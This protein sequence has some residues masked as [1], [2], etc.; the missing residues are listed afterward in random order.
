MNW[1]ENLLDIDAKLRLANDAKDLQDNQRLLALDRA[2]VEAHHRRTF[3]DAFQPA[4]APAE[5]DDGMIHIGDTIQHV[6]PAGGASTPP[7]PVPP[8]PDQTPT[9]TTPPTGGRLVRAVV[10]AASV[11]G[12][13][14]TGAV[15]AIALPHI[16]EYFRP[17]AAEPAPAPAPADPR[18]DN[19]TL[20]D[21]RLGGPHGPPLGRGA[22]P[23]WLS[24]MERVYQVPTD[25]RAN[26]KHRRK[27]LEAGYRSPRLA[28]EL[29]IMS[30]R[31][32]LFFSNT[33]LWTYANK[34]HD[35]RPVRPFILWDFQE[36]L[37]LEV[38]DAIGDHDLPVAKSRDMGASWICLSAFF[39]R[40]MFHEWQSLLVASRVQELVDKTGDPKTLF[41]KLDFLLDHLPIWMRPPG[42]I[43]NKNHL[44]NPSRNNTIEGT[45]TVA[46]MGVGDRKQ[47][48]LLDEAGLMEQ[49]S[50]IFA[51][52]RDTTN[53][54]IFNS[55]PRGV[56]GIGAA[57]HT[58]CKK[59]ERT[60]YL[61]WTA[62][63]IK[64]RGLYRLDG[65][66]QEPLIDRRDPETG[67][68]FPAYTFTPNDPDVLHRRIRS[69]WYDE[70]LE[71]ANS[72]VEIAQELD[73]S[74]VGSGAPYFRPEI[75]Q[76][77]LD[78]CTAPSAI[79]TIE[80]AGGHW[81]GSIADGEPCF[82][83]ELVPNAAEQGADGLL[84]IWLDLDDDGRPP[85]DREYVIGCDI[86]QGTGASNSVAS[87][88][89]RL[90]G[91]KVAELATSHVA[92]A[93]FAWLVTALADFFRGPGGPAL[94]I[95]EAAGPGGT[96]GR[97]LMEKC[98]HS[99]VYWYEDDTRSVSRVSNRAGWW[100]NRASKTRLLSDYRAQLQRNIFLNPSRA[101]LVEAGQ[102]VHDSGGF[103]MHAVDDAADSSDAGENH[104]D[105][106]IADAL[107]AKLLKDVPRDPPASRTTS[108]P[109]LSL[110]WRRE[111]RAQQ[112]R[113]REG[114]F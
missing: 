55:T 57:F 59:N 105:R 18:P 43:R 36:R 60:I 31:D 109:I 15:G 110:A 25:L 2:A 46:D 29:W 103:P 54:R 51:V 80:Y 38:L 14:A 69:P 100:P 12:A 61:H 74:F 89:D 27:C 58:Q 19:D 32:P 88:G 21:L 72:E 71:R 10:A 39:H 35:D 67:E 17:A 7:A 111:H 28:E 95:W 107:C 40:W 47:A 108:V 87:I 50:K 26:L 13:L 62:H 66:R 104:G 22:H 23:H 106:V 9:G 52:T 11:A 93:D 45:A 33:F 34:D 79:G 92:E 64:R 37:L 68:V 70:Q 86:S 84:R 41:W 112:R 99:N 44:E 56:T 6:Y 30:S 49:A 24:L 65:Y 98:Q 77:L 63:P 8:G 3:G 96:F 76:R 16:L 113:D 97:E 85:S 4:P 5:P 91:N 81:P 42:V 101:S 20:F 90:T 102:Y 53:S 78:Q 114:V 75:I 48:I 83:F 94:V 73:I 1:V 82:R